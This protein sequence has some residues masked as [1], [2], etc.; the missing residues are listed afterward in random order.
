MGINLIEGFG[1]IFQPNILFY[2]I[3][4][5]IAGIIVGALPGLSA[6]TGII[7]FLP[8]AYKMPSA[9]ALII[10]LG[11]YGGSMFGGSI[12]AILIRT[13]GTPSAG[14][15][16][17]DGYPLAQ[18]GKAGLALGTSAIASSIGSF[19]STIAL[20]V[21]APQ[22][23]KIALR[24]GPPE[25][26]ALV[27]FG[28][29]AI[30]TV[31]GKDVLKGFIS[32]LIGVV[33]GTVGLDPIMGYSRFSFGSL[34]L[35]SGLP[36][37]PVMIGVFAIAQVF[38][39][40][41]KEEKGNIIA[42]KVTRVL[43]PKEELKG[44]FLSALFGSI[45]GIIIG[46][47]PGI[48]GSVATYVA[49]GQYKRLSKKGKYFGEGVLE[50]VAVPESA[51]NATTG[52]AL[53]PLLT[54]GVPGDIVTAVLLGILIL[55]GIKPGPLLFRENPIL[56]NK[57]FA[58]MFIIAFLILVFGLLS[59]KY[60]QKIV[61]VPKRILTPIVLILCIIG[62]YSLNSSLYDVIVAIVFGVIGYFME[63][64][65]FSVTPLLIALILSPI[66]EGELG[67]TLLISRGNWTVLFTRPISLTFLVLTVIF[68][69]YAF[70]GRK[71]EK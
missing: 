28:L 31:T 1:L 46:I 23:A 70:M 60:S 22:L 30:A 53:I 71:E 29:S 2:L 44:I 7:L 5:T 69:I 63:K 25:F 11:I 37:L 13:P 59:A 47:I 24:F 52:G 26:F 64:F 9:E 15:T 35:E 68:I 8:L 49:Y 6:S 41:E 55:F 14:A 62:A 33:L 4:G 50:G 21:I 36:L 67:R 51:N 58:S 45:V 43:P 65:G 12:P 27:V 40:L 61:Y 20:V 34:Y 54:L 39:D 18:K 56:I 32:A 3:V 10:M 19:L 16:V 57:I 38:R 48:G 42:Q 66:A 17:L